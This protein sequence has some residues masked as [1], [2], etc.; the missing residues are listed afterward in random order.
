[1]Q[2]KKIVKFLKQRASVLVLPSLFLPLLSCVSLKPDTELYRGT[3]PS[4]ELV[5]A[6]KENQ[7]V[8]LG[9]GFN[10]SNYPKAV[11]FVDGLLMDKGFME[12]A[13][14][15]LHRVSQN[16]GVGLFQP[17]LMNGFEN[18][19][20]VYY[21]ALRRGYDVFV[22]PSFAHSQQFLD[23]YRKYKA[24]IDRRPNLLFLGIDNS[25]QEGVLPLG[26]AVNANFKSEESSY[27][28]G[29]AAAAYLAEKYEEEEER[30]VA[31]FGG[32]P[33]S[34]ITDFIFGFLEGVKAFNDTHERKTRVNSSQIDLSSGFNGSSESA[35]I[36][37]ERSLV[38]GRVKV[39]F[40]ISGVTVV[41]QLLTLTE[42]QPHL[43][44]IGVDVDLTFSNSQ[45]KERF[46]S[47]S[48]K[49]IGKVIYD[50]LRDF[51]TGSTQQL[52]PKFFAK[53]ENLQ[54]QKGLE[55]D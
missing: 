53:Q 54:I 28:I 50:I 22:L 18:A 35:R 49:N 27:V 52:T 30:V 16:F 32:A 6:I 47:S 9:R 43:M 7:H 51:Y 20:S 48:L 13:F 46:F 4:A 39:A 12:S 26:T 8:P 55:E 36:S 17:F 2:T 15:G 41:K 11:E 40:P 34:A 42:N 29:Y 37:I 25:F 24:E 5:S 1:M 10:L 45:Y 31:V 3:L 44:V 38:G 21:N 33:F 14:S 19:N 23:F